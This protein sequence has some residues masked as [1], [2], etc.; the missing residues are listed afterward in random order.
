MTNDT[1]G[2]RS[3]RSQIQNTFK[4]VIDVK[5][6]YFESISIA[7]CCSL[8]LSVGHCDS[9]RFLTKFVVVNKPR[10]QVQKAAK[11]SRIS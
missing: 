9:S 1:L 8:L 3:K 2:Y 11:G 10:P 5:L 7:L 6:V 4:A